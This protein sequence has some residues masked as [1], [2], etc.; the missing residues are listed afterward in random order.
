MSKSAGPGSYRLYQQEA[1]VLRLIP[2]KAPAARLRGVV[3]VDDWIALIVDWVPGT[4]AG[5]PWT[6][7]S[8]Q[9]AANAC[10]DLAAITAPAGLPKVVDRLPD[11]DGWTKLATEPHRLNAWE[12]RHIE[13]LVAATSGW[14]RWTSGQ[15]LSHHDVRCDNIIISSA[16][17]RAVLVD[18]GYGCN[19]HVHDD[20]AVGD[21]ALRDVSADT[22]AALDRPLAV[23]VT[24]AGGQHGLVAVGV[25][26]EAAL[27]D[28][29]FTLVDDLD[30]RGPLVRIHPDDDASHQ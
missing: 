4:V 6:T 23:F 26:A 27:P 20:L 19:G 5:P 8:V 11:L 3:E 10:S 30:G 13:D 14:R 28:R 15:R 25:G 16:D 21:Q 24:A 2:A 18:W 17:G 29:L 7:A 22:V 9:A 1:D 12:S